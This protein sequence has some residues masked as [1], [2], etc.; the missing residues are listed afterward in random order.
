MARETNINM[1]VDETLEQYYRRIAKQADQR[2][3]RLEKLAAQGGYYKGVKEWAYARASYDIT[4]KW[5]GNPENP[6]FNT[7]PPVNTN[8]LKAKINDIQDFLQMKTSTKAGIKEAYKKKADS[9]NENFGTNVSWEDWADYL[10]RF[11]VSLYDKYGSAVMNR[12]IKTVQSMAKNDKDMNAQKLH[13]LA[14]LRKD[15]GYKFNYVKVDGSDGG[16]DK[17]VDNALHEIF[18]KRKDIEDIYNLLVGR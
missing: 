5:G 15:G 10:D 13:H 4:Q 17:I 7:K 8:E 12:V 6:R 2:L 9:F 11:G 18:R 14:L 16:Y 3:V 1:R